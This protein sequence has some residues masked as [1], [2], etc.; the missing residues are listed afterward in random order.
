MISATLYCDASWCWKYKV[1][2]W[3]IYCRSD[4][5]RFELSGEPPSYCQDNVGAE[6]SAVFAGLY[7]ITQ[8]WPDSQLIYVRSDC[9]GILTIIESSEPHRRDDLHRL[10]QKIQDL[11]KEKELILQLG[12]V[13]G[14]QDGK[15]VK[16]WVNN[17]VDK[18]ARDVMDRARLRVKISYELQT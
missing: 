1:G 16:S 18:L 4:K 12:W 15:T 3:G 9:S 11:R 6:L 7:R 10:Q 14:H 8:A 2:G 17:R 5:G 13:K